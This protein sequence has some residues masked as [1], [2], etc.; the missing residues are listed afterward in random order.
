M[1]KGFDYSVLSFN[2]WPKELQIKH[3]SAI[4]LKE[5]EM[6]NQEDQQLAQKEREKI[7]K[8]TEDLRRYDEWLDEK[9]RIEADIELNKLIKIKDNEDKN[10]DVKSWLSKFTD[11]KRK[12]D[13]AARKNKKVLR[14]P[15]PLQKRKE[16]ERY[17]KN[18]KG[19]KLVHLKPK[20]DQEVYDLYQVAK[21]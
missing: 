4:A 21:R 12:K 8:E 14:G 13:A 3:D 5:Q 9:I 7:E 2:L 18:M 11:K 20:S 15:T 16:Y 10:F 6:I 19:W 17:L 1:Y